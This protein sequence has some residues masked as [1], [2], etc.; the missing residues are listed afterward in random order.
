MKD[1]FG[2]WTWVREGFQ[3]HL[4]KVRPRIEADLEK[5]I[6]YG[7]SAGRFLAIQSGFVQPAGFIKA[8]IANY[9]VLNLGVKRISP[10]MGA[11]T[12][13]SNVLEEFLKT[14]EPGNIATSAKPSERMHMASSI[15]Q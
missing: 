1:L 3:G 9:P 14:L 11:P 6:T 10:T 7:D 12:F 4:L 5:V 15:A 2:F 8:V 13:T